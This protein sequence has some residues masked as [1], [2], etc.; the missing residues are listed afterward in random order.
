MEPDKVA[1]VHVV[2][3]VEVGGGTYCANAAFGAGE[4]G[5]EQGVVVEVHVLVPVEVGSQRGE[6]E[7]VRRAGIFAVFVIVGR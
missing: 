4:A 3:A 6:V 2:V 7:D 1:E 5:G